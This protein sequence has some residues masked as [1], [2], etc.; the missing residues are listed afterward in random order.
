[1]LAGLVEGPADGQLVHGPARGDG[2][3]E[4]GHR[5]EVLRSLA[6]AVVRRPL[7]GLFQVLAAEPPLGHDPADLGAGTVL[8]REAAQR[9]A[10]STEASA[11][12]PAV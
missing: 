9:F 8:H 1:M 4:G 10:V 5:P 6:A 7:R 2:E 3:G 12:R 11:G